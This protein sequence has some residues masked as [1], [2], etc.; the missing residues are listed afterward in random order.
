VT[1]TRAAEFWGGARASFP[2]LVGATPFG[3][4]FGAVATASNLPIGLTIALSSILFAGSSQFIAIKLIAAGAATPVV[5]LTTA[6]V[7]LRHALYGMSLGPKLRELPQRW[8]MLLGF[9][10]TDEAYMVTAQRFE[11]APAPFMHWYFL[12]AGLALYVVWNAVTV[13]GALAGQRI[14]DPSQWGLEFALDI[15]FIGMLFP[16]LLRR[17]MLLAA[18]AAA[19]TSL[20]AHGLPNQLGLILAALVGVSVGVLAE[21]L[22]PPAATRGAGDAP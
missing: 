21:I 15:T 14:P 20:L 12:G 18:L 5:I 10:M 11:R 4:I 6:V 8:L 19:A 22:L 13:I 2:L 3:L 7:N 16:L 17:P 1:A 9:L